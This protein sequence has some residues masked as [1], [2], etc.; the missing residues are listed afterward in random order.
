MKRMAAAAAITLVLGA[1][2]EPAIPHTVSQ[3]N[4]AHC[5]TCHVSGENG[6]AITVHPE[7]ANCVECH[8]PEGTADVGAQHWPGP[9]N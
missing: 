4:D 8:L 9:T 3:T 7:R 6:A 1:C 2:S 5:L